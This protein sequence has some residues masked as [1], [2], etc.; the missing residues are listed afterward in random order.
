[1]DSGW[2]QERGSYAYMHG[3][4]YFFSSPLWVL[5]FVSCIQLYHSVCGRLEEDGDC[6]DGRTRG[7]CT[8]EIDLAEGRR[9]AWICYFCTG[10][11][12]SLWAGYDVIGCLDGLHGRLCWKFLGFY[13]SALCG[14]TKQGTGCF[15]TMEIHIVMTCINSTDSNL[16]S[17]SFWRFMIV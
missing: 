13:C 14:G 6:L 8:T 5:F 9:E 2:D 4:E 12:F 16:Q 3:V 1:M 7:M 15:F 11:F 10:F 17:W